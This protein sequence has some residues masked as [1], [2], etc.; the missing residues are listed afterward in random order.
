MIKLII[1]DFDGC[2]VD[3]KE[4][5]F[6]ALNTALESI[7][8]KYI[9]SKEEHINIYDGLSTK[10]KISL[11]SVNKGFPKDRLDEVNVLKQKYTIDSLNEFENINLNIKNIILQLKE[12]GY[13]F[14][15]ASNAIRATVDAGLKKIDIFDL[16][17]RIYSNEDVIFQKPNPSIYLKC[18]S[19]FNCAPDET[20][21]IEDSKHGRESAIRSG[22]H[23]FEVDNSYGF[24]NE[25]LNFIDNKNSIKQDLKW[26]AKRTLNV[27]IPM[28]GA[29]SRFS[30]AGY[31]KPKPLIDVNGKPMIERVVENLNV[32]CQF[33]FI[34]Q[35]EHFIKYNLDTYLN[36]ICQNCN[37]IQVDGVTE[38]AACTTLLAKEFINNDKHLLIANSDQIVDWNSSDFLYSMLYKEADGGI[39]TFECL[40]GNTKWSYAKLDNDFNVIDVAE[41]KAIS[42]Y[43]TVGIY[44]WNK[45]SDYIKYTEQMINKNI[46]VNNEFYVCPVYNEAILDGKKIK[47]F[48]IEKMHGIGTPEDL[49]KYLYGI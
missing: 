33:T 38:G 39:L 3:C 29:G 43:A 5:H 24:N 46:R 45:G 44:Y 35:R 19:D 9:I 27:V 37:I 25:L 17:D 22:A 49:N 15:V 30:N 4:I 40:D 36:L 26:S 10:K 28:A 34:V 16:V 47:I 7:D 2:L 18:M 42:K 21:I 31:L 32:D 41:K 48:N 23:L 11:L 8:K 12:K 14:C 6:E 20:I 13:K 1:S